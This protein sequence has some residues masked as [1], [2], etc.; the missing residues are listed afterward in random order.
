M[1]RNTINKNK[2]MTTILEQLAF[3]KKYIRQQQHIRYSMK[4]YKQNLYTQIL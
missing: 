1:S 4:V 3:Y 2:N